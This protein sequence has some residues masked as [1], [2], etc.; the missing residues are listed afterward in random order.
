MYKSKGTNMGRTSYESRT[1]IRK[2]TFNST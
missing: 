2:V 1:S